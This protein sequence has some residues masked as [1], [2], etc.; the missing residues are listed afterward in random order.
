MKVG[1]VVIGRNEGAR[2]SR[3]LAAALRLGVPVVYADSGSTDGSPER[4]REHGAIVLELDPA[5]PFSAARG[6]NEGFER[7]LEEAP[8]LDLVQFVDGDCELDAGWL[9]TARRAFQAH[10][11]WTLVCGALR[12]RTPEQSIY[13]R[14]CAEEWAEPPGPITGCGGIFMVRRA[15]F[16]AVGGFDTSVISA[17]EQ[18]LCRLM[19]ARGGEL[20][21]IDAPMAF[22]DADMQHFS[23]WWV[24]QLRCGYGDLD[25]ALRFGLNQRRV[26]S[27]LVWTLGWLALC[28]GAI[29]LGTLAGGS[30]A[31]IA[32]LVVALTLPLAQA[33]RIA[34]A[35]ERDGLTVGV[36]TMLAKWP[37]AMGMVRYLGDRVAGRGLRLIEYRALSGTR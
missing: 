12:E 21:R 1:I 33:L 5:R 30:S 2:L 8:E 6:R 25:T 31:G 27:A 28:A 23:Q 10:P 35:S 26:A 18:E 22:H 36:F 19:L 24:R 16:E 9:D 3:C 37:R 13:N 14:L 34:R 20:F 15:S 7:L 4:A 29:V 32:G 11:R 17:E